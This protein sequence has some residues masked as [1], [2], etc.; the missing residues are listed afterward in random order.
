MSPGSNS[1]LVKHLLSLYSPIQ[2]NREVTFL[3]GKALKHPPEMELLSKWH[4]P[5]H[6]GLTPTLSLGKYFHCTSPQWLWT[7]ETHSSKELSSVSTH[8]S[9]QPWPLE[10][11]VSNI[12]PQIRGCVER[13]SFILSDW[14]EVMLH[15]H[16]W[17]SFTWGV[18]CFRVCVFLCFLS[19]RRRGNYIINVFLHSYFFF[20]CHIQWYLEVTPGS[21]LKNYSCRCWGTIQ[22]ARD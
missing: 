12:V 16:S 18:E 4:P 15:F 11:C 5:R 2:A 19:S 7:S 21:A 6:S 22:D 8:L 3:Q 14:L 1:S 17:H 20:W 9:C 10:L 13:K